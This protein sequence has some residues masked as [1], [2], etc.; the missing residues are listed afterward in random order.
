[1]ATVEVIVGSKSDLDDVVGSRM[2]DVFEEVGVEVELSSASA[3]RDPELLREY[4]INQVAGDTKV[5]IGI[6]G[7]TPAL[8]GAIAA[9]IQQVKSRPVIGVAL[10]SKSWPAINTLPAVVAMPPGMPLAAPGIDKEG[11]KNAAILACQIVAT[12]DE[13]VSEHLQGYLAREARKKDPEFGINP[14]D[15]KEKPT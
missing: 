2:F 14:D 4:C 13:G 9:S 3:H 12:G 6:A 1:M 15:Y 5:F 11:L 7:M 8:P 10:S